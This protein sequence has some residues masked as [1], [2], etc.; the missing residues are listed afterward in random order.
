MMV[1]RLKELEKH[2]TH[3]IYMLNSFF[4]PNGSLNTKLNKFLKTGVKFKDVC[5]IKP[6][7]NSH[8]FQ[9]DLLQM[10]RRQWFDIGRK[11]MDRLAAHCEKCR[12]F[13]YTS[14]FFIDGKMHY[15]DPKYFVSYFV[16]SL[17]LS[18]VGLARVAPLYNQICH[19]LNE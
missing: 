7:Q 6:D 15:Y 10:G 2:V 11:R 19:T 16:S 9:E 1:K 12:L 17:H 4:W 5:L 8:F 13:D 18:P 14:Q 3:R